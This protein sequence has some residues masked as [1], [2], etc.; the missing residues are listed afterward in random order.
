MRAEALSGW[1][2]HG[3]L[4]Q[5]LNLQWW[6]T[7]CCAPCGLPRPLAGPRLAG[8]AAQ[9]RR[10]LA[11]R[12]DRSRPHPLWRLAAACNCN[13]CIS[14]RELLAD[15]ADALSALLSVGPNPALRRWVRRRGTS[16]CLSLAA[17]KRATAMN[18]SRRIIPI[19]PLSG[20]P[21]EAP[22]VQARSPRPLHALALGQPAGHAV[23]L[24]A[25]PG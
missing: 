22:K 23:A 16:A 4:D 24:W 25:C 19:L 5:V 6:A 1:H 15:D 17:L 8:P 14:R 2:L 12:T 10:R 7:W 11:P 13:A 20:L 3:R 18:E 21:V 9:R